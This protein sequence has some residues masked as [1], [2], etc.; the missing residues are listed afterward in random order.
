M[1]IGGDVLLPRRGFLYGFREER[2]AHQPLS[3]NRVGRTEDRTPPWGRVPAVWLG[4]KATRRGEED[5][6]LGTWSFAVRPDPRSRRRTAISPGRSA[7]ASA[8]RTLPPRSLR[9]ART[10]RRTRAG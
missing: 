3:G 5:L 1:L 4:P 6:R 10:R 2:P 7:M 8:S 9:R